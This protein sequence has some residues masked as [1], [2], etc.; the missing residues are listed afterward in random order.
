MNVGGGEAADQMVRMMLSGGE[1]A[2]R[3]G[4]SALKNLLALT[5]ALAKN[6]KTLSGKVNMGRMLKQTRDLRTFAMTPAQYQKFKRQ[7][8]KQKILFSAV[9][10]ADGKGKF[11]DVIMPV[12]ELDRANVIFERILPQ[13]EQPAQELEHRTPARE[14]PARKANAPKKDS[15]SG[16]DSRGTKTSSAI[17]EGK[18]APAMT[19]E[20]P[21]VE[22]RLKVYRAQLHQQ[23]KSAP[24]KAKIKNK[25]KVK[26]PRA[27]QSRIGQGAFPSRPP[28]PSGPAPRGR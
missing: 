27:F 2:V 23:K 26:S 22:G 6:H 8:G 3:L 14:P 21:S 25:A 17:P 18:D 10:S 12:T 11:I 20:R 16:R 4:G 13:R 24:A 19:S 1:V 15:P 7:A 9:H 5:M 28:P